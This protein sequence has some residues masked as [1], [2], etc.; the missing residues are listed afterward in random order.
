MYVS[1]YSVGRYPNCIL[2]T[3]QCTAHY[4]FTS[5]LGSKEKNK[6]KERQKMQLSCAMLRKSWLWLGSPTFPNVLCRYLQIFLKDF[7]TM[8]EY[9]KYRVHHL[10]KSS[11]V[12]FHCIFKICT[13]IQLFSTSLYDLF[14]TFH[15]Y[16]F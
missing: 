12:S 7:L 16:R 10:I 15:G 5:L 11:I 1:Y 2:L 14:I 4:V 9:L 13:K 6:R 3:V 8:S